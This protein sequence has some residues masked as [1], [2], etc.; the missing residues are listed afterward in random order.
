M[1][2][3]LL[4][5]FLC[6]GCGATGPM[7]SG[8]PF[9]QCA[10]C[11]AIGD[12][13]LGAARA[14]PDWPRHEALSYE[15]HGRHKDALEAARDAGDRERW[16]ALYRVVT[17]ALVDAFP[18]I[19]PPRV[20]EPEYR[21]QLVAFQA[22]QNA[23]LAMDPEILEGQR[24][25]EE[26]SRELAGGAWRTE[27]LWP[28]FEAAVRHF[29]LQQRLIAARGPAL[30]DDFVPDY[31][32]RV[33]VSMLVQE[34]LPQLE[35]LDQRELVTRMG[36]AREYLTAAGAC[37][38]CGAAV[39]LPLDVERAPC[40]FCGGEVRVSREGLGAR[41]QAWRS[42]E[43]LD[44]CLVKIAAHAAGPVRGLELL[45]GTVVRRELPWRALVLRARF[46]DGARHWMFENID[47]PDAESLAE[48][49]AWVEV[50]EGTLGP[51][52]RRTLVEHPR[53]LELPAGVD[54]L[55]RR[56]AEAA[57]GRPRA[58][59]HAISYGETG[60]TWEVDDGDRVVVLVHDE[61]GAATVLCRSWYGA[62][63]T[64]TS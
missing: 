45:D 24:G 38:S 56:L 47:R 18:A 32:R 29:E 41:Q 2:A 34:W 55:D 22:A 49:L 37:R 1:A 20:R 46:E 39:E 23:N 28:L 42:F 43:Y 35:P 40:P 63:A 7:P 5:R 64:G 3:R 31:L 54:D 16:I 9:I 33:G 25:L 21:E 15:L 12:F 27:R 59:V 48:T 52:E 53:A 13:D 10:S 14:N 61:A 62:P 19:Y 6:A 11:G 4:K 60:Y 8:S 57:P 50:Q 26:T 51:A 44:D 17:E 30:P 36:I 58:D